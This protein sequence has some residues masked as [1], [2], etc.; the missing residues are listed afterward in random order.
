MRAIF[1][2]S[3]LDAG[4]AALAG[5]VAVTGKDGIVNLHELCKTCQVSTTHIGTL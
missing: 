5:G 2:G 4:V 3:R 1:A